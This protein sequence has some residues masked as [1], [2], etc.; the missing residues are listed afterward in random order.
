MGKLTL[1][2]KDHT[3]ETSIITFPGSDL[4]VTNIEAE[5]V[6]ADVLRDATEAVLLGNLIKTAHT[7]IVSPMGMGPA[8]DPN[9]QRESKALVRYYDNTTFERG[10]CEMPCPDLSLQHPSYPG[11]FFVAG[12]ANN[13]P[14]WD[15]FVTAFEFFVP[16]PG[17]NL[18]VVEDIIHVG[19]DL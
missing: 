15:A 6:A 11:K 13:D 7:A 14:L 5:F 17:G 8:S 4:L 12:D 19:R 10:T 1:T 16:G 2:Y 3:G 9:A 18:A